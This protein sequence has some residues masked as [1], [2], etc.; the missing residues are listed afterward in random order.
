MQKMQQTED[1]RSRLSCG[2]SEKPTS[3]LVCNWN[4]DEKDF[5]FSGHG[6]FFA[7]YF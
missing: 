3:Q 5:L 1:C 6:A 4:I 2:P 7:A